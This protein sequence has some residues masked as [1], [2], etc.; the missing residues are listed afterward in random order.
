M[1]FCSSWTCWT[2][3]DGPRSSDLTKK[4]SAWY[5]LKNRGRRSD[6]WEGGNWIDN[7]RGRLR[8]QITLRD[9]GFGGATEFRA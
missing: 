9:P 7:E 8:A 3:G 6:V 5:D 1:S 2:G 4:M